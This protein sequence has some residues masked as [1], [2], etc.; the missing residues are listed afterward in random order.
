MPTSGPKA[1]RTAALVELPRV[2]RDLGSTGPQ[3]R[4]RG[5]CADLGRVLRVCRKVGKIG[6]E[7]NGESAPSPLE[8]GFR[9]QALAWRSTPARF[10]GRRSGRQGGAFWRARAGLPRRRGRGAAWQEFVA[11][12]RPE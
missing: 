1:A 10:P 3:P 6:A 7:V 2:H 12:L 9:G 5:L 11:E 4:P 8:A